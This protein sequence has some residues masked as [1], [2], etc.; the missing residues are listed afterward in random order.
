MQLYNI[1]SSVTMSNADG[2]WTGWVASP[3]P[4]ASV[5]NVTVEALNPEAAGASAWNIPTF[6]GFATQ[7]VNPGSP[8]GALIFGGTNLTS[9]VGYGIQVWYAE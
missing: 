7:A 3:V 9:D 5:V 2:Y 6:L 1:G 4:A 8:K